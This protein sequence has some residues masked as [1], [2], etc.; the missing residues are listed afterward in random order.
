M[1]YTMP[2]HTNPTKPHR[3]GVTTQDL[4]DAYERLVSTGTFTRAWFNENMVTCRA[5]GG[6]NFTTLGG[7]FQLVGLATYEGAGVYRLRHQAD[8]LSLT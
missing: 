7:L 8:A 6:C 3:K 1:I 5:E 2:S 4:K